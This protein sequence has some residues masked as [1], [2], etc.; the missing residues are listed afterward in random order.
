MYV[1]VAWME[2]FLCYLQ[3]YQETKQKPEKLEE[4]FPKLSENKVEEAKNS[5]EKQAEAQE[6]ALPK[7]EETPPLISREEP[8]DLLVRNFSFWWYKTKN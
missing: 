3:E 1:L 4:P 6:E 7:K 2:F 5:I 8:A